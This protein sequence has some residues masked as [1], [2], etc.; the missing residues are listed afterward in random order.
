M[1]MTRKRG[2]V[3]FGENIAIMLVFFILL[4]MGLLFYGAWQRG[5]IKESIQEQFVKE[6]IRIALTVSYL[7]EV[8]CSQDNYIVEN[9]F[10]EYKVFALARLIE[11]DEEAFLEYESLFHDSRV[12]IEKI[13]PP[14]ER[15]IIYLYGNSP[16]DDDYTEVI[17]TFVPVTLKDPTKRLDQGN[18][19]AILKVEVFR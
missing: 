9:C 1:E 2:Q 12:T 6:A 18:S 10:D 16:A 14:D 13:F 17:P 5:T 15:E 11:T 4:A 3:K 19:I 8:V 7:P